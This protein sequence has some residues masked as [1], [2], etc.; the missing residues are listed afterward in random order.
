MVRVSNSPRHRTTRISRQWGF[1]GRPTAPAV[2]GPSLVGNQE[3]RR[4]VGEEDACVSWPRNFNQMNLQS[5]FHSVGD[6]H[7]HDDHQDYCEQWSSCKKSSGIDAAR[8]RLV[9][10]PTPSVP[11]NSPIHHAWV[12]TAG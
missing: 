11:S 3:P 2:A 6:E 8:A 7:G 12:R 9:V 4:S 1:G 10:A 5:D